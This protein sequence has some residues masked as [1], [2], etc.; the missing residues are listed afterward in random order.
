MASASEKVP[1]HKRFQEWL[2][3]RRDMRRNR[4]A[5]RSV[6]GDY[7]DQAEGARHRTSRESPVG[8]GTTMGGG[9]DV[10]GGGV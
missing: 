3:Y 8:G 2:G 10:G 5:Y 4:R 1:A 9:G 7:A 6:R